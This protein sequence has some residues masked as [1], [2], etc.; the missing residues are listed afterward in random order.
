MTKRIMFDW[1]EFE[2]LV[3]ELTRL[4]DS[5]NLVSE[6]F[7]APIEQNAILNHYSLLARIVNDLETKQRAG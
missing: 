6:A 7:T 5:L 1:E 2:E 4:K 3:I